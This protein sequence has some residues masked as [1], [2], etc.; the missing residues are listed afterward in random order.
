MVFCNRSV[1]M[2]NT[3]MQSCIF[4]FKRDTNK[5]VKVGQHFFSEDSISSIVSFLQS[6]SF[7]P[8]SGVFMYTNV[9]KGSLCA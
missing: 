2:Q 8:K 5:A 6:P 1:I 9:I 3:H 4:P 7:L